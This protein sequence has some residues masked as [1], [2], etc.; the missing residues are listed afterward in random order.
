MNIHADRGWPGLVHHVLAHV[1]LPEPG[2]THEPAYVQCCARTEKARPGLA[3]E[4]DVLARC[5]LAEGRRLQ[6]LAWLFEDEAEALRWSSTNVSDLSEGVVARP[7][8]LAMLRSDPSPALE[9]LRCACALEVERFAQLSS[10]GADGL[11]ETLSAALSWAPGLEGRDIRVI[12]ALWRRGRVGWGEIWVGSPEPNSGPGL[13]HVTW[14]ACHEATVAELAPY[15]RHQ[16]HE[17]LE[18]AA[19]VLLRE[20]AHEAGQ[21]AAWRRWRSHLGGS[22]PELRSSLTPAARRLLAEAALDL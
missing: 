8:V 10:P 6:L 13:E 4:V 21:L 7:D 17:T 15:D 22:V 2:G 16:A 11:Q 20:R 9:L 5:G 12:P 1:P 14:Q 3:E 18:S 19:L